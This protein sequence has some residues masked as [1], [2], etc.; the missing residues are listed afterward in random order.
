MENENDIIQLKKAAV[1]LMQCCNRFKE[2]KLFLEKI[3]V[4]RDK[5]ISDL[6]EQNKQLLEQNR[7]LLEQLQIKNA[8]ENKND[9]N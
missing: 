2:N 3:L 8:S 4:S 9:T 6:K 1:E 5:E 7:L